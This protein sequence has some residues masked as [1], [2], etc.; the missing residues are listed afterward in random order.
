MA[1]FVTLLGTL[2]VLLTLV[3]SYRLAGFFFSGG[4]ALA[5]VTSL[6]MT[7]IFLMLF[8][9]VILL[10]GLLT[11]F[12]PVGAAVYWRDKL[13]VPGSRGSAQSTGNGG[14]TTGGGGGSTTGGGTQAT[15]GGQNAGIVCSNCGRRNDPTATFCEN[16]QCLQR[17]DE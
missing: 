13:P 3:G 15:G 12:A 10:V 4:T 2:A 1:E 6:A 9:Q 16:D 17:L 8:E 14:S 11:L 5:G 7:V